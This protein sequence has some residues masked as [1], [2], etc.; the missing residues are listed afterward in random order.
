[1]NIKFIRTD[2]E[3]LISKTVEQVDG[4]TFYVT[5]LGAIRHRS[6]LKKVIDEMALELQ[7]DEQAYNE[8]SQSYRRALQLMT[9]VDEVAT[10]RQFNKVVSN[11][12]EVSKLFPL[13][14]EAL[15]GIADG[16]FSL[17]KFKEAIEAY[18]HL[19]QLYPNTRDA[20]YQLG[21]SLFEVGRYEEAVTEFKREMQI[22]GEAPDIYLQIG[23]I[24]FS[25]AMDIF[26]RL[27]DS[28]ERNPR[29]IYSQCGQRLE[30]ARE[31]F[32][33]GI[34]VDPSLDE[35]RQSLQQVT[36]VLNSLR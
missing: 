35:L 27:C 13:M 8:V 28:G 21:R 14:I 7:R 32:E 5:Q 10:L 31:A 29:Q 36:K 19:I 25:L 22:S 9:E 1:M 30:N 24:H 33:M 6:Q 11:C 20:H 34:G 23:S 2:S 3:E 18:T 17:G 15:R 16:N 26:N 12:A 4:E